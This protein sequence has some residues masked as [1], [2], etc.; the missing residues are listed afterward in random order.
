M[1]PVVRV[2]RRGKRGVD[3]CGEL[4]YTILGQLAVEQTGSGSGTL[5]LQRHSVILIPIA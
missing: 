2:V 4:K 1:G 5:V 3:Y